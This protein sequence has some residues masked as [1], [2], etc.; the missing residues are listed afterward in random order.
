MIVL[1]PRY[2]AVVTPVLTVE[3]QQF[4]VCFPS[5]FLPPP[6]SFSELL[7]RLNRKELRH[8]KLSETVLPQLQLRG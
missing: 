3:F 7:H 1:S 8:C 2:K 5:R 4:N 6:N